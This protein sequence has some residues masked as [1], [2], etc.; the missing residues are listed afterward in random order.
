[1]SSFSA[2]SSDSAIA[3]GASA[4]D[5]TVT[6][7]ASGATVTVQVSP[8]V[9][10]ISNYGR[11]TKESTV[12]VSFMA[13]L[14]PVGYATFFLKATKTSKDINATATPTAKATAAAAAEGVKGVKGGVVLDNGIVSLSFTSSGELSSMSTK[15][16]TTGHTTTVAMAQEWCYYVRS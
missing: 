4:G 8:V 11:D 1:M 15:D 10:S 6:E 5:Y 16:E 7:A 9:E 14:P 13:S 2:S 12:A 3:T